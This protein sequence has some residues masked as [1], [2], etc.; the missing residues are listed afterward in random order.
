M[1]FFQRL[2]GFGAPRA[3]TRH[4]PVY[5]YSQRCAEAIVGSVDLMNELSAG[6]EGGEPWFV[7]K[8]FHTSGRGR[9][10]DQV[11]LS[12]W[13]DARKQIVRHEVKGG[14]WLE[15]DE[16]ERLR[17]AQASTLEDDGP[18]GDTALEIDENEMPGDRTNTP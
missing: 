18:R 10:F 17:I 7:R 13:L 16:Y 1:G 6:E 5:V 15:P 11:E 3:D 4:L 9:C 2:F 12:L 14:M 8:V